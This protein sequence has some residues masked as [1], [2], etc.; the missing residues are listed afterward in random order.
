MG[1]YGNLILVLMVAVLVLVV[2]V[3]LAK[4]LLRAAVALALASVSVSAI[5]FLKGAWMAAFFELSVC[6]GLITVLFMST[7]SLTKDSDQGKE[8]RLPG[9]PFFFLAVLVLFFALAAFAMKWL[10]KVIP[11][12]PANTP[13]FVDFS[14]TFWTTRTTDIIGQVAL[15]MAGVFAILA[16][17]KR[18]A[19]G[20]KHD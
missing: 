1:D 5:L 8:F 12:S 13:A 7:L 9:N 19:P 3:V 4:D 18:T 15:I 10:G 17:F 2:C 16:L 14:T 11:V 6:A 20:R